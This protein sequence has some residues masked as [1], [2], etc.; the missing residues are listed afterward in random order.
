MCGGLG[1]VI[2]AVLFFGWRNSDKQW[3]KVLAW[4]AGIWGGLSLVGYLLILA[5]L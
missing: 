3:Q 2:A 5:N 4:I 1:L